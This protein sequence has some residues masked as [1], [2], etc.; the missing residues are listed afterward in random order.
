MAGILID[1]LI[2]ACRLFSSERLKPFLGRW[3]H[4]DGLAGQAVRVTRGPQSVEGV[5]RGITPSGGLMLEA[6]SGLS[7]YHA[8]E[9][10]LRVGSGT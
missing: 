7:E 6:P 4:Y 10:S 2:R 3:D 5:Y 1:R 8:G 9:V